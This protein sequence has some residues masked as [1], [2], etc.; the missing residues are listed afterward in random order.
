MWRYT[1]LMFGKLS[2]NAVAVLGLG[3]SAVALPACK[4]WHVEDCDSL[5]YHPGERYRVTVVDATPTRVISQTCPEVEVGTGYGFT[6][7]E[8]IYE[9]THCERAALPDEPP[10]ILD[11]TPA[12]CFPSSSLGFNCYSP[13]DW[14]AHFIL[15][16]SPSAGTTVS[17]T[18]RISLGNCEADWSVSV[19]SL[20]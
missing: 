4:A 10:S 19:E 1:I 6:V 15:N 11:S 9:E 17:G 5:T 7:G 20:D 3:L 14:L 2:L 13:T 18:L 12:E 8:D 16:A